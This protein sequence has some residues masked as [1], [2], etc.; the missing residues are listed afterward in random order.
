MSFTCLWSFVS[1]DSIGL[2]NSILDLLEG[3]SERNQ[4]LTFF[5]GLI[6]NFKYVTMFC[7]YIHTSH[8]RLINA[9]LRSSSNVAHPGISGLLRRGFSTR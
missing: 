7:T 1:L 5:I 6:R 8:D 3:W 9:F 2:N 4:A